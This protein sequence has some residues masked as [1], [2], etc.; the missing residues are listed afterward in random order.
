MAKSVSVSYSVSVD[1]YCFGIQSHMLRNQKSPFSNCHYLAFIL[2]YQC[3]FLSILPFFSKVCHTFSNASIYS[4]YC[5]FWISKDFAQ[6]RVNEKWQHVLWYLHMKTFLMHTKGKEIV[7]TIVVEYQDF[8]ETV[9]SNSLESF[10]IL[11]LG[12]QL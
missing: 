9:Y 5:Q 11:N 10:E 8:L 7:L 2:K 6:R 3:H 1:T 12:L 4:L